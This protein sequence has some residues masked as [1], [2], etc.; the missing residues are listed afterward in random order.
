[1]KLTQKRLK[2][3][4]NY[5]HKTGEF[6]RTNGTG[7]RGEIGDTVG[8]DHSAGYIVINILGES[9]L[10]HRLAWFLTEGYMPESFVDHINGDRKDNRRRNLRLVSNSCNMQN[11]KI[12]TRNTSG[13]K[14]VYFHRATG[15]W[16]A[17]ICVNG[18]RVHLGTHN[19]PLDAALARITFEDW[20]NE[21][22]CDSRCQSRIKALSLVSPEGKPQCPSTGTPQDK[23]WTGPY[24][25]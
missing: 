18:R 1:M 9:F 19:T 4:L 12:N 10:A 8:V 25:E 20:C 16:Q 11:Q 23:K 7:I 24:I 15:K 6:K 14:G 13:F 3:V 22:K 2:E 21:W 5:N 17:A